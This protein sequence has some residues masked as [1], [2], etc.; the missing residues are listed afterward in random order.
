MVPT[1]LTKAWVC[2]R[3]GS[4]GDNGVCWNVGP[5]KG[6][7]DSA[8][9][10]ADSGCGGLSPNPSPVPIPSNPKGWECVK[11]NDNGRAACIYIGLGLGSFDTYSA[12]LG[13]GCDSVS[14]SPLT[15]SGP[16]QPPYPSIYFPPYPAGPVYPGPNPGGGIILPPFPPG[17][18]PVPASFP[19]TPAASCGNCVKVW[20]LGRW[21][22]EPNSDCQP[23]CECLH[24][25]T[26]DGGQEGQRA[27]VP[28]VH[29]N[30][31]DKKPI[32]NP[33]F[34]PKTPVTPVPLPTP[35]SPVPTTPISLIVNCGQPCVYSYLPVSPETCMWYSLTKCPGKCDCPT[36]GAQQLLGLFPSNPVCNTS[37]VNIGTCQ[38]VPQAP[39]S[40]PTRKGWYRCL[41]QSSSINTGGTL[42]PSGVIGGTISAS[43]NCIYCDPINTD[44]LC[45][46]GYFQTPTAYGSLQECQNSCRSYGPTPTPTKPSSGGS[47]P[48]SGSA[49]P[50][51]GTSTGGTGYD[52]NWPTLLTATATNT[53]DPETTDTISTVYPITTSVYSY[54]T[55]FLTDT[56]SLTNT[57]NLT[58]AKYNIA[59]LSGNAEKGYF[60]GGN[61]GDTATSGVDK[62]DYTT[63]V[64]TASA[65]S[66]LPVARSGFSGV[67]D[68]T[69][70]GYMAGGKEA[71]LTYSYD[72]NDAKGLISTFLKLLYSTDVTT[73]SA[74]LGLS[75][76]RKDLAAM[77]ATS[78]SGYFIGGYTGNVVGT[79][80]KISYRT[81]SVYRVASADLS[82]PRSLVSALDGNGGVGFTF[83][84]YNG[85]AA[86]ISEGLNF[87]TDTT[88]TLTTLSL[89]NPRFGA[90]DISD[91]NVKGFIIGGTFSSNYDSKLFRS[92]E[93]FIY[94]TLTLRNAT[95]AELSSATSNMSG[96]SAFKPISWNPGGNGTYIGGGFSTA[97]TALV[98]KIVFG[99]DVS[100]VLYS[101]ILSQAR[102]SGTGLSAN[103]AKGYFLAGKDTS[104]LSTSDVVTYSTDT[105][106]AS[107]TSKLQES[108]Y[109]AA[110]VSN[111]LTKG[112]I[113]GGTT[114][115]S[116]LTSFEE[117]NYSTDTTSSSAISL[118]TGRYGLA[119]VSNYLIKGYF[120]GGTDDT[121]Y[122][123]TTE[124][125]SFSTE[126]VSFLVS[127]DLSQGRS[128]LAGVDGNFAV[129]YFAGGSSS[130]SSYLDTVDKI[131]FGT[132]TTVAMTTANLS[133]ARF[134]CVGGTDGIS[135]G[136]VT[137]GSTATALK[138]NIT[139]KISYTTDTISATT[140]ANLGTSRTNPMAIS[141]NCPLTALEGSYYAGGTDANGNTTNITEKITYAYECT[142][143]LTS[144][145]LSTARTEVVGCSGNSI[146]GYFVGSADQNG[147]AITTA[148]KMVYST[149]TT[150]SQSSANL[151]QARYSL[152]SVHSCATAGYFSGGSNPFGAGT[153]LAT[154][155]KI[156]YSSDTTIAQ[157]SSNLTQAKY[158][159][160][161]ISNQLDA[162]YYAGGFS[163]ANWKTTDKFT[164]STETTTSLATAELSVGRRFLAGCDGASGGTKGYFA[165]G[166]AA[167]Y[168]N[169]A[170]LLNYSTEITTAIASANLALNRQKVTG[171]S[172]RLGRGYFAGGDTGTPVN[173]TER[174][175]FSTDTSASVLSAY[176]GV[177]RSGIGAISVNACATVQG[178]VG[179][180]LTNNSLPRTYLNKFDFGIENFVA[181]TGVFPA[182]YSY[183]ETNRKA[184]GISSGT[185]GIVRILDYD[186]L[187]NNI[188]DSV[189]VPTE[190][191]STSYYD[192]NYVTDVVTTLFFTTENM[193][194]V[195]ACSG[196]NSKGYF[197][198]TGMGQRVASL[199]TKRFNYSTNTL[200][201]IESGNL[202]M[203]LYGRTGV[204][205]SSSIGYFVGG[206]YGGNS[207]GFNGN[208]NSLP[209]QVVISNLIEKI[210]Y[211]TETSYSANSTILE[212]PRISC[213]SVANTDIKAYITS[214]YEYDS[215][216][217]ATGIKTTEILT[218]ANEVLYH[219][220]SA[221]ITTDTGV[222]SA[223][224][225]QADT[226]Y[227]WNGSEPPYAGGVGAGVIDSISFATDTSALVG[228][229]FLATTGATTGA[230]SQF[231]Q[232]L[233][234]NT[235]LPPAYTG[236]SYG[237]YAVN[238]F[239]LYKMAY[240][241]ES[242]S[243]TNMVFWLDLQSSDLIDGYQSGNELAYLSGNSAKGYVALK[244]K[245][246][247]ATE[248]SSKLA[249]SISLA[250]NGIGTAFGNSGFSD[251][252]NQ[253]YFVS[254][255][256][257]DDKIS[258]LPYSTEM[259]SMVSATVPTGF[260]GALYQT[261]SNA[262]VRAIIAGIANDDYNTYLTNPV[263]T[264]YQ[265]S[266]ATNV[267]SLVN[268]FTNATGW[269]RDVNVWTHDGNLVA[270]Y[271]SIG[272]NPGV[273]RYSYTNDTFSTLTS[274]LLQG[275]SYQGNL[276]SRMYAAYLGNETAVAMKFDSTIER[277]YYL[278]NSSYAN[279]IPSGSNFSGSLP[280]YFGISPYPAPAILE[281]GYFKNMDVSTFYLVKLK[282][283]KLVVVDLDSKPSENY[284]AGP[285]ASYQE[286]NAHKNNMA[287]TELA[288]GVVI[289]AKIPVVYKVDKEE[290]YYKS[291]TTQIYNSL[292]KLDAISVR[293]TVAQDEELSENLSNPLDLSVGA[294]DVTETSKLPF[295]E[296]IQK[297]NN[298]MKIIPSDSSIK[299]DKNELIG[300]NDDGS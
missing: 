75:Q 7:F 96:I 192:V 117:V 150:T 223:I 180:F 64:T 272:S 271:I 59:G 67:S 237:S 152:A 101:A 70:A 100:V 204:S 188:Q 290:Y 165:G 131:T 248:T 246:E 225:N 118:A 216:F 58:V 109:G 291:N 106:A 224:S 217:T 176:L 241:T 196:D 239:Y 95:S 144:S 5:G 298:S 263:D 12:C 184:Y 83:Y 236:Y 159:L 214:G 295:L 158:G 187:T 135:K 212:K 276:Q 147:N 2:V 105:S 79:T 250:T 243:S 8:Q 160:A 281:F 201:Y 74:A 249:A 213:V 185:K 235:V 251:G 148:D 125:L 133:I 26:F 221:D 111:I 99:N 27:T 78:Q 231:S 62:L 228:V 268:K 143:T 256:N 39:I 46:Q 82:S 77:N 265:F 33:E 116:V 61:I 238:G 31:D 288:K 190:R 51:S 300:D 104:V 296:D 209:E 169:V 63:N 222:M 179:Y 175:L 15:P 47:K 139:D 227:F 154:T 280:A 38:E 167:T 72:E 53:S 123:A 113:A 244:T 273:A 247:Y 181:T 45:Y 199:R 297:Q 145:N 11:G 18:I 24:Q 140:P 182:G 29:P 151:T 66:T 98:E 81:E 161:A 16:N 149:E 264:V 210:N 87:A 257:T 102:D 242:W 115:S 262:G 193:N 142:N 163:R 202:M 277:F 20:K 37:T 13:S 76:A 287:N 252:E 286:A 54:N 162:G 93:I 299:I 274:S 3:S 128:F 134:G 41:N 233:P 253:G 65:A 269:N 166:F 189:I 84:G 132:D 89:L 275:K 42:T 107:T 17:Y 56:T 170:D 156:V 292:P 138:T 80:D 177:A 194:S 294:K 103:C 120:A 178:T 21:V 205:G 195:A 43:S 153:W 230:I 122:F 88:N 44:R 22:S 270:G 14:P 218:F 234:V 283:G 52:T 168:T 19:V 254:N 278:L 28:C 200:E 9:E 157:T 114:G 293:K 49:T 141:P 69:Q 206:Y 198:E 60:A 10:C 197:A 137:G 211:V 183:G 164:F 112:Y 55:S 174:I 85:S 260:T 279:G 219:Q 121:I 173:N 146:K 171:S 97:D 284:V 266:Y 259:P 6:A 94:E 25:P 203:P 207:Y 220:S 258:K 71:L 126:A 110:A 68:G 282:N 130:T 40:Q 261:I 50:S 4:P 136:Y 86:A 35:E 215:A 232:N 36:A 32:P 90:I 23:G 57:A 127:A 255:N 226:G 186:I 245:I 119:S 129:G 289:D 34:P 240:A 267:I 124:S 73:A 208:Y 229:T 191:A 30:N 91:R 172:E 285:F 92:A 48:G 1:P 155:D 108:R